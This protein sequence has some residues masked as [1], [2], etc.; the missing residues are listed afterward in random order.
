M[1][2]L[3][4]LAAILSTPALADDEPCFE[5]GGQG[6]APCVVP[7]GH[8]LAESEL[9]DWRRDGHGA[10]R[11]DMTSVSDTILRIGLGADTEARVT[12]APVVFDRPRG[13]PT[14]RGV[15]DL[16]LGLKHQFG[17][18]EKPV[19][20]VVQVTVPTATNGVGQGTWS[21]G[22]V[23]S[24]QFD[25]SDTVTFA[26]TAEAEAEADEDRHGRHFSAN[27]VA[28]FDV[29]LTERLTLTADAR[30]LRDADPGQHSDEVTASLSLNQRLGERGRL[31][32]E[33]IAGLNRDAPPVEA[34]VGVAW[35]F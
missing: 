12:W 28:G 10:D 25:L 6:T 15:G 27:G 8:V 7:S 26:I 18:N 24:T 35:Q 23:L 4:L 34:F 13:G 33:G 31:T 17:S 14:R 32:L 19:G 16:I 3:L 20:L 29:D 1:R 11:E 9:I 21:G 5:L 30:Y 2:R 22:A